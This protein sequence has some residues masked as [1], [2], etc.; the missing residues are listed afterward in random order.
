[1]ESLLFDRGLAFGPLWLS[2]RVPFWPPG[3]PLALLG[4]LWDPFGT[5]WAA[6]GRLLDFIEIWMAECAKFVLKTINI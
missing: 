1:M 3:V 5:P 2:F 6:F 4:Y